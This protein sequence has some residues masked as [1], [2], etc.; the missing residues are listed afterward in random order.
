MVS[1]SSTSKVSHI[2][3]CKNRMQ[4]LVKHLLRYSVDHQVR[5]CWLHPSEPNLASQ[6][7]CLRYPQISSMKA[8]TL[9]GKGLPRKGW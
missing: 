7:R 9:G 6:P 2:K 5:Q 4:Q 1:T 8:G 3:K